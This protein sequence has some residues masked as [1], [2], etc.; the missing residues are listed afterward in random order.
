MNSNGSYQYRSEAVAERKGKDGP[1]TYAE[2]A[3]G[4]RFWRSLGKRI[5]NGA[6]IY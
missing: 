1:E 4:E 5:R 3:E 2:R 6:R